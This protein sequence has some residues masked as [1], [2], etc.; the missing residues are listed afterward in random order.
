MTNI[1]K[2]KLL[3]TVTG[4]T[5]V[6][7]TSLAVE[8]AQKLNTEIISCDSRQVYKEMRIGTAVPELEHLQAIPHHLI[9]FR[10]VTEPL[11]ANDFGVLAREKLNQLFENQ[12]VV[13]MVGGSGL[14]I[15]SV[16]KGIDNIPS[17]DPIIREQIQQ[18]IDNGELS[19]LQWE[20]KSIDPTYYEQIDIQN[21]RR[22][23]RGLEVYR[24]SGTPISQFLTNKSER[25]FKAATIV[26]ELDRTELYDKINRRVDLMIEEGLIKEAEELFPFRN[27]SS[28][29]TVG[30]QELFDY[31]NG[32]MSNKEAIQKIKNNSRQYARKQ[33]T[34]FRRYD[35][36]F[37]INALQKKGI[38]KLVEDLCL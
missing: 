24:T 29:Q 38:F 2:N 6:G 7:K 37:R 11:N 31:F 13:V 21:P 25:N 27:L 26:L 5:A 3:L 16:L 14:Y 33:E 17:P 28:L 23:L 1:L 20:L 22:I 8:I 10:S 30:Y 9:Q 35:S 4:P 32:E 12:N 15:D 36:A 18:Q 19:K 34:W